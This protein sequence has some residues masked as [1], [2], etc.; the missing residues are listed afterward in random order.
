M[1]TALDQGAA[2]ISEVGRLASERHARPRN[3]Q[4]LARARVPCACESEIA[5]PPPIA[6]RHI[7]EPTPIEAPRPTVVE[8][9]L[10][11]T[12]AQSASAPTVNR[13]PKFTPDRRS[14]LTPIC[15]R[16]ARERF[17]RS[18]CACCGGGSLVKYDRAAI[19]RESWRLRRKGL[20]ASAG[21]G[22][23]EEGCAREGF[24]PWWRKTV[25]AAADDHRPAVWRCLVLHHRDLAPTIR[26]V[27]RRGFALS[28]R[29]APSADVP[30]GRFQLAFFLLRGRRLRR[31]KIPG[32]MKSARSRISLLASLTS[33]ALACPPRETAHPIPDFS[34]KGLQVRHWPILG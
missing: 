16:A 20:D 23:G 2:R 9:P 34:V 30:P 19:M 7:E 18:P 29:D 32:I 31:R 15:R 22:A 8:A 17:T 21:L 12:P 33:C 25:A 11:Q 26:A 5:A 3:R 13:H 28:S 4:A 6:P 10:P 1:G 27:G 14:K 24:A